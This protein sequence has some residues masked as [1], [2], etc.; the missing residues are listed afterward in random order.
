MIVMGEIPR[1]VWRELRHLLVGGAVSV[2]ALALACLTLF[3]LALSV[4]R[5]GLPLLVWTVR[6]EPPRRAHPH[7]SGAAMRVVIAETWRCCAT[8]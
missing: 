3:A 7:R 6:H 1:R 4:V 5:V 2:A 8:G